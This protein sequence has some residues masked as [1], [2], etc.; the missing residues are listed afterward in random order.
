MLKELATNTRKEIGLLSSALESSGSSVPKMRVLSK[1]QSTAAAGQ[2]PAGGS[3]LPGKELALGGL[4]HA[5]GRMILLNEASSEL[6]KMV[7]FP[8]GVFIYNNNTAEVYI[9]IQTWFLINI[10]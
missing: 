8:K 10:E 1:W 6:T 9:F 4:A 7:F 3:P 2:R 5:N